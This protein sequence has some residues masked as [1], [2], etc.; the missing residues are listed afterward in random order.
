[1]STWRGGRRRVLAIATIATAAAVVVIGG[2]AAAVTLNNQNHGT[3]SLTSLHVVSFKAAASV[4]PP[5]A[6][7]TCARPTAFTF[8]GTLSAAGP[9][10]VMYRWVYSSGKPGPVQTVRFTMAG[11]RVV[12]GATV[13]AEKAGGG[14]GEIKMISPVGR[15]SNEAAYK[16]LCGGGS[17]GGITATA[18]VTPAV[19]TVSCATAPPVFTATGSIRASKA[20]RVTYYW[21]QSDG[22]NSAPATLTFTK[23]GT[24]AAEPLMIAPPAASGS[25]TAVLVVTRPV[26]TASN[27]AMYTLTCAATVTRPGTKQTAPPTTQ[28]GPTDTVPPPVPPMT[29]MDPTNPSLDSLGTLGTP[30]QV[31]TGVEGGLSPY[32]WSVA[33]LPPGVTSITQSN[34]A[35]IGFVGTPT[36][37]GTFS[38]TATVRD[39]EQTPQ[40]M[41]LTGTFT[42]NPKPWNILTP[43][44]PDGTIGT[45]YTATVEAS[46]DV[47]VTW[48]ASGLPAGLSINPVT[49]TISG[50]PT[51]TFY[52]GVFVSATVSQPGAGTTTETADY[53][54]FIGNAPTPTPTS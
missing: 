46:S 30:L 4:T 1:M 13:K 37:A 5:V 42:I 12:T 33:G 3:A 11:S 43:D 21:A 41:T 35:S 51:T 44:L 26:A 19:R 24:Q 27:P 20:E 45:F 9:G 14:W 23:P 15:T 40:T 7:S 54:L 10:T 32:H 52:N 47:T 38:V 36:T 18:T 31:G 16:L 22:V 39:S 17:I 53:V 29:V 28:A 34:G 48:S 25:G 8:S 49:G 2:V 50:T 6:A